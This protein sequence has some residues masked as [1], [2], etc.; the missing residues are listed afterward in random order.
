MHSAQRSPS[1][2]GCHL[3]D[4]DTPAR[5]GRWVL[6]EIGDDRTRFTD[7]RALKAYAGSAPVTRAS[8][9]SISITR[10][11]VKN[12]RLN[13]VGFLWA[14]ATLPPPAPTT[15]ADEPPVTS[16]PPPYDTC[17][18]ALPLLHTRQTYDPIKAFGEPTTHTDQVAA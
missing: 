4:G 16:T 2:W 5:C 10:H 8:G 14:F 13:A 1:K 12:D 11:R 6:A 9:R 18:T 17:L 15:T 7:A 3:R